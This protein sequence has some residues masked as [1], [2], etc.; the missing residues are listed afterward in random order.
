MRKA[1]GLFVALL[2]CQSSFANQQVRIA[3]WDYAGLPDTVVRA[4]VDF[5]QRAFQ[6]AGVETSWTICRARGDV[7]DCSVP[8]VSE[9]RYL[10]ML[11]MPKMLEAPRGMKT[12]GDTAGFAIV[13]SDAIE[14]PRA[15][16]FYDVA[17][18]IAAQTGRPAPFPSA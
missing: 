8:L 1:A 4:A 3:V 10:T 9:V 6:Q 17:A 12:E 16:A 5:A 11:V 7:A 15:W 13:G 18:R 2:L 14:Q